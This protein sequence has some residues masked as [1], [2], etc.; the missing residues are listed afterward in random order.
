MLQCEKITA[1][2]SRVCKLEDS[3]TVTQGNIL[4]LG[5]YFI[6]FNFYTFFEYFYNISDQR[7][8][9]CM[10]I[11]WLKLL[12]FC[13][14]G[15]HIALIYVVYMCNLNTELETIVPAVVFLHGLPAR[16]LT[17]PAHLLAAHSLVVRTYSGCVL[18][19]VWIPHPYHHAKMYMSECVMCW[20]H[21]W[22]VTHH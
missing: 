10:N 2:C 16:P 15:F 19:P 3:G 18:C 12:L 14:K 17:L 1:R 9:Y 13:L 11:P 21:C 4:E 22:H 20:S 5:L 6:S 7:K 8:Q